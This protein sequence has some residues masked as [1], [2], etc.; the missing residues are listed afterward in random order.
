VGD[1]GEMNHRRCPGDE[2]RPVDRLGEIADGDGLHAWQ[3]RQLRG[4]SS[5]GA[6][7]YASV[8]KRRH[9]PAADKAAGAG[10]ED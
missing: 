10:D 6:Y 8:C 4:P 7:R 5:G 2:R 3:A 9:E 1:G